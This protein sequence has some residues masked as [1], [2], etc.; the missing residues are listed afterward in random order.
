MNIN[1]QVRMGCCQL[2]PSL[3]HF[4]TFCLFYHEKSS[5]YLIGISPQT[6]IRIEKSK[7]FLFTPFLV[8]ALRYKENGLFSFKY[9]KIVFP[10]RMPQQSTSGISIHNDIPLINLAQS[11]KKNIRFP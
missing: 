5:L 10:I 1:K 6:I 4:I 11:I 2:I 8:L 7:Y 9:S 3:Y